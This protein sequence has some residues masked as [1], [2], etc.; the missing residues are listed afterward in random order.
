MKDK[1]TNI[2]ISGVGG[3]GILLASEVLSEVLMLAGYDVKKNEIHG[4]AQRG[5]S[6]VSHIRFGT[7][8]YSSIIPEG[9]GDLLL[10]FEL[11]E[12]YRYLPLL[13]QGAK[14][15]ANDLKILP[16]PVT[17]GK[18]RYPDNIQEKIKK[19][20]PDTLLVNGI[21]LA[22]QAGN[23]RTVNIA[24]LGS[25]VGSLPIEANLWHET[26]RRM[27]PERFLDMNLKAFDLGRQAAAAQ[28]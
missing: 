17:L 6:V 22:T 8:V 16:P 11:L 13:R 18:E 12:T 28:S 15:V 21:E 9:E 7:K 26:L 1:V 14:V 25:M 3:Q 24:L 20:F 23:P 4:M 2:L 27:V 5:G 19:A 10:G